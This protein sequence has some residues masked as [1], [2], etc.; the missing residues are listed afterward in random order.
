[1]PRRLLLVLLTLVLAAVPLMGA[2]PASA[3]PALPA[4]FSLL[5]Y[6]SGQPAYNLTDFAWLPGGDLLTVGKDGKVTFVPDGAAPRLIGTVPGVRAVDDHGLLGIAPARDFDTTGHVYLS[7][8]KGEVGGTGHA[9]LEEWQALPVGAPTTFTWSRTVV[10]GE[11]LSPALT[12]VRTIHGPDSVVVAP[13]GT[14]FWSIGDDAANNGD[15]AALRA[16]DLDDAHG[17]ILHV[18][19]DGAGVATNPFYAAGD[20]RSVRSMVYAYGFRN[21]FRFAIDP[22]SGLLEV[23]DVG[24]SS[25]E[26]LSVLG[27]GANAGWP[28]FEGTRRTTFSSSP[29]CVALE[30]RG[31]PVAPV[32]TYSHAGQGASVVGGALYTGTA[33]PAAYRDSFFLGDYTRGRVWTMAVDAAGRMTRAPEDAG[34]VSG[35]GGPVAFHPGPNGDITYADLLTGTIRRIVYASGNRRPTADITSSTDPDRRTVSFSGAGSYDPDGDRLTYAWTFG[36]GTSATGPTPTH[37]YAST[38]AQQA[39]LTVTDQ[40][41]ATGSASVTVHPANHSPVLSVTAPAAAERFKVGEPVRLSA[42]AADAEDGTLDVRYETVLLHCPFPNSCHLHPD[43]VVGGPTYSKAYTDHGP[44]TSMQ[45]TVSATDS[46]GAETSQVYLARP[47]LRTLTVHSRF[48]VDI[49]GVTTFSSAEVEAQ[50]V[51][52]DAPASSGWWTFQGWSDGGARSHTIVMPDR[53]VVLTAAYQTFIDQRYARLGGAASVLGT[54]TAPEASTSGGRVRTY[55]RGRILWSAATGAH[56]VHGLILGKFLAGGGTATYGFPRTDETVVRGGQSSTFTRARIYHAT[57]GGTFASSGPVLAKYLAARGPDGYGLPTSDVRTITG[58]SYQG[59]S[60][61]RAI[62][63][64]RTHGAHLV[65]G[66]IRQEYSRIGA[67]RSCLGLPT[68]DEYAVVGGRRNDFTG[69]SIR[70]D[71]RT[72]RTSVHC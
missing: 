40:L 4:G 49:D 19:T 44:D 54:P 50:T 38:D 18:T 66:R 15:P 13:D 58:G 23:G 60:G 24:W 43:G 63:W 48:P 70:F 12:E 17:K 72:G 42:G 5:P 69:G 47:N 35:A 51:R 31:H 26:E 56:E 29:V 27:S 36:D 55:Q 21:P 67:E 34:F 10:D 41:G 8:D 71:T 28:C 33:Y 46:S 14:L 1:M 16:Q 57:G 32:W 22:R 53:D 9:M 20:P 7:Y 6:P 2:S 62:Y 30:E 37:T 68:T 61:G 25:V 45:I 39:T 59:F 11:H 64:S 52:L 65:Y 3:A